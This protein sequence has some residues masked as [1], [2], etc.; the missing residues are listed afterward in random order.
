VRRSSF[1]DDGLNVDIVCVVEVMPIATGE[2]GVPWK[3]ILGSW[4]L[5]LHHSVHR[6]ASGP[7][8]ARNDVR[9]SYPGVL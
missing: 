8:N 9:S 7:Y 5:S 3:E 2:L 1:V 4:L 6:T